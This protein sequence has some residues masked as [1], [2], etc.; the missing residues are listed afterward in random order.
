MSLLELLLTVASPVEVTVITSFHHIYNY[1]C[2]WL[3]ICIP[4]FSRLLC[5]LLTFYYDFP[6]Q[7]RSG[8]NRENRPCKIIIVLRQA[9]RHNCRPLC[10]PRNPTEGLA[11]NRHSLKGPSDL[12]ILFIDGDSLSH[13]RTFC[14]S[15]DLRL[16][17][18]LGVSDR[19]T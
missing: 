12:F 14:L 18:S 8:L 17:F 19:G 7:S 9:H 10:L 1:Y 3:S 15:S 16:P 2:L 13:G 6:C 11:I 4:S 5:V